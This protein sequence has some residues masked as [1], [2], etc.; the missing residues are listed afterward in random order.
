MFQINPTNFILTDQVDDEWVVVSITM[1]MPL[2]HHHNNIGRDS[3]Q[4]FAVLPRTSMMLNEA[5]WPDQSRTEG[6]GT[7]MSFGMGVLTRRRRTENLRNTEMHN[8]LL[9]IRNI[10][11]FLEDERAMTHFVRVGEHVG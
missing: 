5:S 4:V 11:I 6:E 8:V 10:R 3:S 7:I 9:F 1:M 2:I